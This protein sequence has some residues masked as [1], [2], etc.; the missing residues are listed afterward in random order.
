MRGWVQVH[1]SIEPID[2]HMC[3]SK[4]PAFSP[5]TA[6]GLSLSVVSP[7]PSCPLLFWPQHSM[8][9]PVSRAHTCEAPEVRAMAPETKNGRVCELSRSRSMRVKMIIWQMIL[10][11]SL[12]LYPTSLISFPP[13]CLTL[14]ESPSLPSSSFLPFPPSRPPFPSHL[15]RP[16]LPSLLPFHSPSLP[17]L[18]CCSTSVPSV[19]CHLSPPPSPLLLSL[20]VLPS[21]HEDDEEERKGEEKGGEE[22]SEGGRDRAIMTYALRNREE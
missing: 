5:V 11:P 9:P 19:N 7:V 1:P 12:Q 15:F 2:I 14:C 16:S 21:L 4:A 17:S 10:I 6:V 13:S 20:R 8:P 22:G 18:T 3:S